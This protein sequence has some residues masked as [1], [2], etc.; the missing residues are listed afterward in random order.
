GAAVLYSYFEGVDADEYYWGYRP[1]ISC[2]AIPTN[3]RVTCA[4]VSVPS[5]RFGDDLKGGANE[6]FNRLIR[7]TPSTFE[8]KLR[9][10]RRVEPIRGFAGYPGRIRSGFGPGWALVGDAGC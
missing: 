5:E 1:G 10:A 6:A 2:G 8:A 9:A 3:D 4:F 7:R